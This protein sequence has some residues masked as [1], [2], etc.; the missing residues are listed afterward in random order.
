MIK[1]N[2]FLDKALSVDTIKHFPFKSFSEF[3]ESVT[4]QS[5]AGISVP[6]DYARNWVTQSS[7]SPRFWHNLYLALMVY[8]FCLPIFYVLFGIITL[9][10]SAIMYILVALVVAFTGSPF[11]MKVFKAH[12]LVIGFYLVVWLVSGSFPRTIYWLPV[13]F[14]YFAFNQLYKGSASIVRGL[15]VENEKI[16]CLFW[17]WNDAS[18]VLNDG[19]EYSQRGVTK[20]GKFEINEDIQKEWE[21][22]YKFKSEKNKHVNETSKKETKSVAEEKCSNCG[23]IKTKGAVFCNNCGQKF[24]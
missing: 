20:N 7:E 23:L 16:L 5:V 24:N 17:K 3:K 15:M 21:E 18:I 10:L 14:Q 22:Y 19:T 12:Y 8:V 6:M 4:N 11:A 9:D 1:D 2:Y 13:L